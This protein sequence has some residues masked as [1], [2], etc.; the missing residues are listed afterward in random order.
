MALSLCQNIHHD[1]AI[2]L[3]STDNDRGF[4]DINHLES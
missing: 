1:D 2:E 3:L 4:T